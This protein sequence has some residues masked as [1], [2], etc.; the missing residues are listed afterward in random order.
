MSATSA[1]QGCRVQLE[2]C[3]MHLAL[4]MAKMA[5]GGFSHAT[6][7]EMQQLVKNLMPKSMKRR[8]K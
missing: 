3:N 8:S 7:D 6:I 4:N 2:Q 5:K 1:R